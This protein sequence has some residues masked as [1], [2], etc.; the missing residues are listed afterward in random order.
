MIQFRICGE[1][2]LTDHL[3]RATHVVSI[4]S[5]GYREELQP[6]PQTEENVCKVDFDDVIIPTSKPIKPSLNDRPP[7]EE[8]IQKV[9]DFLNQVPESGKVLFHCQAGISRS[10]GVAFVALCARYPEISAKR[11]IVRVWQARQRARP[12]HM[13]VSA[14]DRVL[15]L[16]GRLAAA[17]D[18]FYEQQKKRGWSLSTRVYDPLED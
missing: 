7:Q 1:S 2:E 14:G 8:D 10:P 9:I 12:N 11:H 3:P 5:P 4:W 18:W 15:A 17:N 16:D 13:V 6:F